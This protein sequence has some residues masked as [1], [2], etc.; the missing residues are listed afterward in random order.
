MRVLET[1]DCAVEDVHEAFDQIQETVEGDLIRV[2]DF[3][4]D[5]YIKRRRGRGRQQPLFAPYTWNCYDRVIEN[6]QRTTNT[7][8]VLHRKLSLL[9]GKAHP[10]LFHV[11]EKMQ[12]TAPRFTQPPIKLSTG[13]FPGVKGGQSVVPTTPPHSSA[14]VMESMGLYLH[15]PKC[16]HAFAQSPK[17]SMRQ[18]SREIGI[19]KSSV[20]R[21]LRAQKWKPHIPRLVHAL[22]EDD[23]DMERR[24]GSAAEFPP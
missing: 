2:F 20:H 10:S 3:V 16:L 4:E 18:C 8:E 23:P 1:I 17:K 14:E 24:R 15:A 11:L 6:L 22:T 9:M 5:N 21:I 12:I 13:S 19:S 7:F